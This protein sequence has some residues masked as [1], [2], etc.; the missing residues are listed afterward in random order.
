MNTANPAKAEEDFLEGLLAAASY[1]EEE[2]N[3]EEMEIRRNGRKLF[4]FTTRPISSEEYFEARKKASKYVKNPMNRKLPLIESEKDF[5]TSKFHS[6]V[7]YTATIDTDKEKIWNNPKLKEKTGALQPV[8]CIPRT[9]KMGEMTM[10]VDKILTNSG[11]TDE[12][13]EE[14]TTVEETVKN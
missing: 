1:M 12:D 6:W 3:F 13:D 10:I 8:D 4:S 5:S 7:I 14:T 9:L 11:I 2:E